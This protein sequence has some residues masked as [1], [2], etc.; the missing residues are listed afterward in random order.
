M[1]TWLKQLLQQ[2]HWQTYPVFCREYE[3]VAKRID[4]A[5]AGGEPSRTQLHRWTTGD[6][7]RTPYADHCRVLEGMFPGW[8]IER[9]LEQVDAGEAMVPVPIRSDTTS[10]LAEMVRGALDGE[11]AA[12]SGWGVMPRSSG[13]T[14]LV[15]E[16]PAPI[17][18]DSADDIGR[19]LLSLQKSMRLSDEETRRLAKLAGNVVELAV[20]VHLTIGADGAAEFTYTHDIL[21]LT[22]KPLKRLNRET[23][24]KHT[25]G[26]LSIKSVPL[27][28]RKVMIQR[29]HDA[30]QMTKFACQFSPAVLPGEV[31]RVGYTCTGGLFVD[32]HYWRHSITR[33]TRHVTINVRHEGASLL[34]C[35]AIETLTDGS[36]VFATDDIL[37]D[38]EG[39]ALTMTV[40]R[41]YL[42]PDQALTLR[43][44]IDARS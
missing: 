14:T 8:T 28:A 12:S 18:A 24:F 22:S 38:Q 43:W 44:E 27:D 21:N 19:R 6:V 31:A 29:T 17:A 23:W 25:S 30:T 42:S 15:A 37:W 39:D 2:R 34:R 9:L 32:E 26:P 16:A 10:D 3:R 1:A 7:K 35:S 33:H 13:S 11:P 20:T 40:A 41:D 36:E 4:P 5:L